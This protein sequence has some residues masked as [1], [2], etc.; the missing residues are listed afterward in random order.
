M[1]ETFRRRRLREFFETGNAQ[2]VPPDLQQRVRVRLD[3]L[4]AASSLADL[5]RPGFHCHPLRG[6]P[7]GAPRRYAIHVNG[8]WRITFEWRGGRVLQVD[9]EQYH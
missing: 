9:L 3:A 1:I 8:P 2:A 4:D 5:A 7:P 6:Q